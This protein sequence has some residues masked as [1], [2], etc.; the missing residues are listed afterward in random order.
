[1]TKEQ[2]RLIFEELSARLPY[3]VKVDVLGEPCVVR[4]AYIDDYGNYRLFTECG[5]VGKH[6]D[7]P[8]EACKMY[9]R[10]LE[11]MT[12]RERDEGRLLVKSSIYYHPKHIT[13]VKFIIKNVVKIP[14]FF[15]EHHLDVNKLT[16]QN[17]ALEAT[18]KMY[19]F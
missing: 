6:N 14:K 17:L 2:E 12:D 5:E 9:L 7:L 19:K 3:G 4:G 8:I 13:P 18:E 15:Y 10:P 11:S 16:E 1:M